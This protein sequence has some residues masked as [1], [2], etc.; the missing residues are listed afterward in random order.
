MTA[1]KKEPDISGPAPG[2]TTI[3]PN[4][5][6]TIARLTAQAVPGVV[7]MATVPG[8]VNRLFKRGT[9]DGVQ[10]EVSENHVSVDLYLILASD[11]NVRQ[12]SREVQVEV[13]RAIQ[14]TV[15]MEVERID[16]HIEDVHFGPAKK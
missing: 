1:K 3:A 13:A 12:V 10:I 7:A 5:L 9:G 11:T 15:G 4:V 2:T 8:G 16:V 14:D 6:L